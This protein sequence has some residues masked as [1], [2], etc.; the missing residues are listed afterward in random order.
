MENQS[1]EEAAYSNQLESK[2]QVNMN[3]KEKMDKDK[4]QLWQNSMAYIQPLHHV[5]Q[6]STWAHS[7]IT[8]GWLRVPYTFDQKPSFKPNFHM[9]F[10]TSGI[11]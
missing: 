7:N 5:T 3:K 1:Q 4:I 9:V 2:M 8:T 10:T 6:P 11:F